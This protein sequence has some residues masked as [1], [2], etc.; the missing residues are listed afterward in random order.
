[1]HS[2]TTIRPGPARLLC[3]HQGGDCSQHSPTSESTCPFPR[4]LWD[5]EPN[6]VVALFPIYVLGKA[7]IPNTPPAAGK[8]RS[9]PLLVTK[10]PYFLAVPL[11][12]IQVQ[13]LIISS[14]FVAFPFV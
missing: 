7:K 8:I 6:V 14:I 5:L 11:V 10:I 3:S 1:M 2:I 9:V 4:E 12:L 13:L